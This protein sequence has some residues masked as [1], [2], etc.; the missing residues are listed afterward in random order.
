[1]M[2][3]CRSRLG[4]FAAVALLALAYASPSAFASTMAGRVDRWSPHGTAPATGWTTVIASKN[5]GSGTGH[6]WGAPQ[7]YRARNGRTLF[8]RQSDSGG[9][10]AL[11]RNDF[12]RV[13][14]DYHSYVSLE[15]K[16]Q[17]PND[18]RYRYITS[19]SAI[20]AGG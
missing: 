17:G 7:R 18:H 14:G 3:S 15:W 5:L 16:W 2:T 6:D 8:F 13:L 10:V 4:L 19:I 12:F 1:M 20:R 9:A 11:S